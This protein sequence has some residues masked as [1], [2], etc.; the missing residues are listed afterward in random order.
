LANSLATLFGWLR[1][2][3]WL[4]PRARWLLLGACVAF[5]LGA[6]EPGAATGSGGA[7]A[8]PSA[9]RLGDNVVLNL[10]AA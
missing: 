6:A 2:A 5:S 8:A 1:A 4:R 3:A 10:S 9:V 7:S